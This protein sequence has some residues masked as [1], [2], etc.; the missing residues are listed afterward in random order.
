MAAGPFRQPG[1]TAE[2]ARS[3]SVTTNA[4]KRHLQHLYRKFGLDGRGAARQAR[5]AAAALQRRAV[6]V[7]EAQRAA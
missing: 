4:V 6:T 2:I 5:L 7:A 1:S 3:L